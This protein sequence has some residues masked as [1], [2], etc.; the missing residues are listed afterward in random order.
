M[1]KEEVGRVGLVFQAW[2]TGGGGVGGGWRRF[3]LGESG[4]S[5]FTGM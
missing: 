5:R 2:K 3:E 4:R 1:R